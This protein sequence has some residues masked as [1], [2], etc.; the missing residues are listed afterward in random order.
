MGPDRLPPDRP[1]SRDQARGGDRLK[2]PILKTLFGKAEV[3]P[4]PD[5]EAAALRSDRFR[6][7][8]E[9][10]WRRLEDIVA[11]MEKGRLRGLSD[12]DV[13]ALPALYRTAASSLAVARETSL[14]AAT[15]E[16]L[17]SLVQRAWFQVY[18]PRQ[19][20]VAWLRGFLGGGL[21]RAIRAI[22]LDICIALA[23]TVAGTITG[24]LLVAQDREWY[25]AFVPAQLADT[26]VPGA[27][28]EV[29]LESLQVEKDAQGLSAFA[30]FLFSNNAGVAILAFALGFAFGIP[31][32][33]LLIHNMAMLGAILWLY[34]DAGLTLEFAAWLSVHGTTELFAILLAGAAGMHIGRSMAFPGNR[35]ILAAAAES[36][37][38]GAQVMVGVVLMLVAA[39]LLE[40]FPRQ[41]LGMEGRLIIGCVMLLFWLAYF[42]AFGRERKGDPA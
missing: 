14:D 1:L 13:L 24:W 23:V 33:M 28:R 26:R 7:E 12:E 37:R 42:F 8:R 11:R 9:H 39:A 5:I 34:A 4:P 25:Y 17:D 2:A 40:A 3:A 38:R 22:W 15:L 6:L 16:Y 18:G 27:S 20:F 31:S 19:G 29:L 10:D 32:L 30:A 35:S 21:S 36:G 41:L